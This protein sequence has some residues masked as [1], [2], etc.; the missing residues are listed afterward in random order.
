[1][2][3]DD[4]PSISSIRV[5]EISEEFCSFGAEADDDD[6]DPDD[7]LPLLQSASVAGRSAVRQRKA[8][9]VQRLGGR[10]FKLPPLCASCDDYSLHT[11]ASCS[12]RAT[13]RG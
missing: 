5:V 1:V 11:P 9:R 6:S 8:R 4:T 3:Q 12:A 10:E 7:A 2:D 13:A